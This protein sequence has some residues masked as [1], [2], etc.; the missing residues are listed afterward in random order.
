MGEVSPQSKNIVDIDLFKLLKFVL[1]TNSNKKF[2]YMIVVLDI[3]VHPD[4]GNPK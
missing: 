1:I 3:F 2:D 4:M